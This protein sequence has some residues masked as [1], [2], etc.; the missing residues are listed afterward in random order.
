[1]S[2]YTENFPKLET[3]DL[4]TV[5]CQLKEVCGADP[6]G[7]I[8]AQ[9][10][11]RPTT[12]KDIALLLSITYKLFQS[13]V[14]L[15][16]QF[17]ELYDFVKYYYEKIYNTIWGDDFLNIILEKI[18]VWIEENIVLYIGNVIKFVFFGLTENGYFVAYIPDSWNEIIFG[19]CMTDE[20]YGRLTLTY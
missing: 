9:F 6:G 8:N 13:Q 11:S 5:F 17:V 16:K 14:G 4:E 10:L 18:K 19:T 12:A 15:Q 7:L 20:C 1:M 3:Y 2:K